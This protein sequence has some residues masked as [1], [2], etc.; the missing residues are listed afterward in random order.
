MSP[1]QTY[2]TTQGIESTT[3][4]IVTLGVGSE[5]IPVLGGHFVDAS[6]LSELRATEYFLFP[7]GNLI[8]CF[9]ATSSML[10][11][12]LNLPLCSREQKPADRV[13]VCNI[14]ITSA[15]IFGISW[16]QPHPVRV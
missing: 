11:P 2:F 6:L 3:S 8:F 7:F 13:P 1:G 15:T 12:R 10:L 5:V 16:F 9:L 4:C 14:R